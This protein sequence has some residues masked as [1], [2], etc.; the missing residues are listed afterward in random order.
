VTELYGRR[1][2]RPNFSNI[3]TAEHERVHDHVDVQVDVHVI[4]DVNRL[5]LTPRGHVLSQQL[6]SLLVVFHAQVC[7]LL[8]APQVTQRIF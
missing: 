5:L 3:A 4:V 6:R 2:V 1:P 8:L 7:D